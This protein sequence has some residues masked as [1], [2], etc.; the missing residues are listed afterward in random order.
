MSWISETSFATGGTMADGEVVG[1]DV[2]V[3]PDFSKGWQEILS[4]GDDSLEVADQVVNLSKLPYGMAFS[5]VNWVWMKYLMAVTD[6]TDGAVKTHTFAVRNTIL[7]YKM[8]WAKRHTTNH[9]LTLAGNF[10]KSATLSFSKA[11]SEGSEGLLNVALECVA[12]TSTRGSSV[13]TLTAGNIVSTPFQYHMAKITIDDVETVEVNNGEMTIGLGI[14]EDDSRYCNSTLDV[15][16]GEPIPGVF[17]V[18]GRFNVNIKDKT[19]YDQWDSGS[20][21]GTTLTTG[22]ASAGG[23]TTLTDSGEGWSVDAYAGKNVEITSG[24]G[25]GQVRNVISNT[26]EI[27]T[28]NTAWTTNPDATSVYKVVKVCTLL[29]DRDGTGNDQVLFTFSKFRMHGAVAPTR[30]DGV[31]NVDI[32]WTAKGFAQLVARDAIT[33]Y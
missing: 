25:A 7:S 8:E 19:Q 15:N 31:T 33:A 12:K 27:L 9:V 24:T 22:T 29:F 13:T 26:S 17:R 1:T 5:P 10:V 4:A 11:T 23:A 16:I 3:T 14:S 30:L 20:D 21:I 18:S 2:I 28:V 6:S 32:V